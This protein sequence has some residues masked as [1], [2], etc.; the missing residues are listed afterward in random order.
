[1]QGSTPLPANGGQNTKSKQ[2]KSAPKPAKWTLLNLL[3][4]WFLT[5]AGSAVIVDP[6][7][8]NGA[9]DAEWRELI[10][11]TGVRIDPEQ[12]GK[13]WG[14]MSRRDFLN[15]CETNL[16]DDRKPLL[17]GSRFDALEWQEFSRQFEPV[18][19]NSKSLE[20]SKSRS[21]ASEASQPDSIA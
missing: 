9:T 7:V 2:E 11:R 17:F 6:T 21:L 20:I 3:T 18:E 1:M 19:K 14:Q 15:W 5:T 16:I 13:P 12:L 4:T 10:A 8:P